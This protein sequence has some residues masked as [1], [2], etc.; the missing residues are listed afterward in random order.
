M[1][2][3]IDVERNVVENKNVKVQAKSTGQSNVINFKSQ[4]IL[5]SESRQKAIE[6]ITKRSQQLHW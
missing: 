6:A 1:L 2:T 3:S 5:E 4:N